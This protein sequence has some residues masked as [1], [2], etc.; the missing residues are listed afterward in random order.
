M[1]VPRT[2]EQAV[3]E[4][5]QCYEALGDCEQRYNRVNGSQYGYIGRE[6]QLEDALIDSKAYSDRVIELEAFLAQEAVPS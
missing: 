1:T 2:R 5:R 4:L 6:A 3:H